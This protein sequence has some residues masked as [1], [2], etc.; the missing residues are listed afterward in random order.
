MLLLLLLM[1]MIMMILG[2]NGRGI[3]H[4]ITTTIR[5]RVLT[6][7]CSYLVSVVAV[8]SVNGVGIVAVLQL[9]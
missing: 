5:R 6:T 3:G 9:K 2:W 1:M 8:S 7:A 4:P